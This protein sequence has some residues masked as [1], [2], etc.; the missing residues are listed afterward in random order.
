MLVLSDEEGGGGG[1]L[2]GGGSRWWG[3][4]CDPEDREGTIVTQAYETS[5][6][7]TKF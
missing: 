2:R 6:T 1:G 5:C 4:G 7:K 3:G